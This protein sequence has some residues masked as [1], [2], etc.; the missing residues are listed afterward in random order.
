MGRNSLGVAWAAGFLDGE[1]YFRVR[2]NWVEISVSQVNP[3][4]LIRLAQV[5]GCGRVHPVKKYRTHVRQ[6]W[7]WSIYGDNA[8]RAAELTLPHLIVKKVEAEAIVAARKYPGNTALGKSLRD[9][10]YVQRHKEYKVEED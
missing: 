2:G 4:P 1:G 9:R 8:R 10:A 3:M 5:F 6:P 7:V